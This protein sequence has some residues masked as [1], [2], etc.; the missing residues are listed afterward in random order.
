MTTVLPLPRPA[1]LILPVDPMAWASSPKTFSLRGRQ[2]DVLVSIAD[3]GELAFWEIGEKDGSFAWRCTGKIRTGRKDIAMAR[4][5]SAK[6]TALGSFLSLLISLW[7]IG[8]DVFRVLV[9][10]SKEGGEELTI[11]DS[12]ESEFSSGLE[13][14][15]VFRYDQAP[16]IVF[17]FCQQIRFVK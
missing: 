12:K 10:R 5:S 1:S 7:I 15:R 9:L 11:W 8:I 4:C 16:A 13:Y 17:S 3:D 14:T 2:H 6:K